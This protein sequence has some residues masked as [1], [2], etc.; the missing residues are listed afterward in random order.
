MPGAE[1]LSHLGARACLEGL[2]WLQLAAVTK[3]GR[4]LP[5]PEYLACLSLSQLICKSENNSGN[6]RHQVVRRI[7]EPPCVHN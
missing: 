2:G 7:S 5:G 3:E 4:Q 1:G 6:L